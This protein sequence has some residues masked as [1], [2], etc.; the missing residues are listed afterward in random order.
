VPLVASWHTNLHEYAGRRLQKLCRHFPKTWGKGIARKGEDLSLD[1]LTRFYRLPRF[2]MA[3][4]AAM[5]D[6]LRERTVRPAFFMRHGVDTELFSPAAREPRRDAFCI[7]SVGRLTAEKNVRVFAELEREL[8]AAGHDFRLLLI[9]EGSER[10][11]LKRNLRSAE[12]PGILRGQ[13]LA[14][15][16]SKMDVF[17]FPSQ[18]D[19]FGLVLL[20]A[21]ATGV[22]VIVNPETGVR[23]GVTHGATGF[24]SQ[25]LRSI[26]QNI[27][28]LA[29]N[30]V[31]RNRMSVAARRFACSQSWSRVF[32][33]VY[34]TYDAGL[35]ECGLSVPSMRVSKG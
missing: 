7:G 33:Q 20:E 35:E 28:E 25:D 2:L 15:A 30:D 9:G 13:A 12:L 11:W 5:V 14:S 3:P 18:T 21:M 34:E 23:V 24:L 32:E 31:L 29:K 10:E 6:L 4:N 19:T 17:V 26:T 8:L 16:Y 27:V 1:A 22:P